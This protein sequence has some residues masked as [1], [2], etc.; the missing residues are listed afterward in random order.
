VVGVKMKK[1]G[2]GVLSCVVFL[3]FTAGIL[4]AQ[5]RADIFVPPWIHGIF[6]DLGVLGN[7]EKA[8]S[9]DSL[10]IESAFLLFEV[11]V[12]YDFGRITARL[13]GNFGVPLYGLAY[14]SDGT[15]Y[16]VDVLDVSNMKF[17]I[18]G[19]FK[20]IDTPRFDL[21]LPLGLVFSATEYTQKNPSYTTNK[22]A[23]DRKW[24][25]EYT[26]IVSGLDV[27]IQLNNHLK[28]C[29]LSSIGYPMVRNFTYKAILQGNYVWSDTGSSTSSVKSNTDVFTFSAGVGLRVN[30]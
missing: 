5:E 23:F 14:F 28:L 9:P 6:F 21:L 2:Y 27:M 3:F 7:Y 17:G 8:G 16:V 22:N 1:N 18:E 12:G 11:G 4:C 13:Y 19:A 25:Y 30:F 24:I 10:Q 26:S 29:I 20:I 15:E